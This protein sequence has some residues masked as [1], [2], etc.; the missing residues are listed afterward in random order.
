MLENL[1]RIE[2][3]PIVR[4]GWSLRISTRFGAE[5]KMTGNTGSSATEGKIGGIRVNPQDHVTCGV[6]KDGMG[7]SVEIIE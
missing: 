3:G 5:E 2:N 4:R 1:A 7:M 6:A